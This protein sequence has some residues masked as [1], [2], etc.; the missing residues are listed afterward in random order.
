M[1]YEYSD[2]MK[3]TIHNEQQAH[4]SEQTLKEI[5]EYADFEFYTKEKMREISEKGFI[6]EE[7]NRIIN[8]LLEIR[9]KE[10]EG[11]NRECMCMDQLN[12]FIGKLDM[13]DFRKL[14]IERLI[15]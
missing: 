3:I 5:S 2:R 1:K 7:V 10:P 14:K 13:E 6:Q 12:E 8:T 11:S 4:I 15:G 9:K